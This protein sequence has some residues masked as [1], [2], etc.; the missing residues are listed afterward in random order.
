MMKKFNLFL[1]G[2]MA[3]AF[4]ACTNEELLQEGNSN[5][6][7]AEQVTITAYTPG[8]DSASSRIAQSMNGNTV[9]LSWEGTEYISVVR[10]ENFKKFSAEGGNDF[11]GTLPEGEGKY[12]AVYP[13]IAEEAVINGTQVPFDLSNQTGADAYLMYAVSDNHSTYQFHHA[14]AY[15]KA[16]FPETLKNT[17]ATITLTVPEGVYTKGTIDLT[18]GT[19]SSN[20]E[21]KN[22]IVKTVVFGESTEVWFALP[23]MA[24]NNNTL[25]FTIKT[26]NKSYRATLA[27]SA[28]K[29]IEAGKYYSANITMQEGLTTCTLPIASTFGDDINDYL[30]SDNSVQ[31]IVFCANSNRI[32]GDKI[33]DTTGENAYLKVEGNILYISTPANEFVFNAD[34]K[35]M[36]YIPVLLGK[37][38]VINFN[39][40]INTSNVT[41][42]SYMFKNSALTT[43]DL[44]SFDTSNVTN[45]RSMFHNCYAL[46]TLDLSSFDTSKVT[47]MEN[48]F[49][50]SDNLTS[51]D[52]SSFNTSK[53]TNM[54]Y[55]FKECYALTSLDLSS[56]DA[57]NVTTMLQMFRDCNQL[58]TVS[59]SSSFKPLKVTT[60]GDMFYNCYALTTLDLSSFVTTNQ[61]TYIS[62]MFAHC[63]ALTTLD[64]SLFNTE[65]VTD[66]SWMFYNCTN[67]TSV[68]LSSSFNTENVTDMSYMFSGCSSLTE[69][70]LCSFT[71]KKPDYPLNDMYKNM[72]QNCSK[73]TEVY[74]ENSTYKG[75]LNGRANINSN[76]L[77]V[78]TT[79]GQQPS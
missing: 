3:I 7:S 5:G 15:L 19:L 48:M 14:A 2:L 51:V 35:E 73:L 26:A 67:L 43:L 53:V 45:M 63:Y 58:T 16:T 66:M 77:I 33:S 21:Y 31:S 60:M 37:L 42:M 39:N 20:N 47:N 17:P 38:N 62:S 22:T 9:K 49:Y 55:M 69:L 50:S 44:S 52:L 79:H 74:V 78:H 1:G 64:L 61:L 27:G 56:F 59:L 10:G 75:Y 57:S 29:A 30:L 6:P 24:A 23:P 40:C 68:E 25:N 11:S 36:F 8:D 32:D 34:C 18:N 54:S 41:D 70:D 13:A 72:F 76:Y 65:K 12:Y 46:T 71:F 4:T 28:E